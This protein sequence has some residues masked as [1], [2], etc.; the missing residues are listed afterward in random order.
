MIYSVGMY[1]LSIHMVLK[2]VFQFFV[3]RL[4][5]MYVIYFNDKMLENY[6]LVKL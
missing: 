4:Y 5:G 1:R 6:F 3:V 2:L